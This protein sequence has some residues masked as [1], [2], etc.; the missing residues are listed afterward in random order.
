M[1]SVNNSYLAEKDIFFP[2]TGQDFQSEDLSNKIFRI[3]LSNNGTSAEDQLICLCPGNYTSLAELNALGIGTVTGIIDDG[4][5]IA[6]ANKAVT[7]T[8]E[9]SLVKSFKRS[10]LKHPT[11]ITGMIF[12]VTN[13][14]QFNESVQVF[15]D[16]PYTKGMIPEDQIIPMAY[17]ANTQFNDKLIKVPL[18]H[19]QFDD[20]HVVLLNLV[21][22]TTLTLTFSIG[23]IK[24][25][26][27]GLENEARKEFGAKRLQRNLK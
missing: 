18:D 20:E 11:R 1:R 17:E 5:I 16:D 2:G 10:Y 23:A 4:T 9:P 15:L 8:G 22:N 3:V 6:T 13:T 14:A 27:Y 24:N 12:K 25:I 7:C 21:A 26:N 19:F